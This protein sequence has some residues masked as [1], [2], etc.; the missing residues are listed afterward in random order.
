MA[1]KTKEQFEAIRRRSRESIQAAALRL[2][3]ERGYHNTSIS[4][5]TR[6]AGVSKGLVYNY[7]ES[8]QALL[9]AIVQE[10]VAL[11]ESQLMNDLGPT[12]TPYEQLEQLTRKSVQ[13]VTEDLQYWKLLTSLTFQTDVVQEI[14]NYLQQKQEEAMGF[15]IALFTRLGVEAPEREAYFYGATMD[16]MILHYMQNADLYGDTEHYALHEMTDFLLQR[17]QQLT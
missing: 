13:M 14:R 12:G 5:I 3:A 17:Y 4:Q 15:M 2:F 7:F 8:K 10:A 6:E 1:P 11:M 16:G 9:K